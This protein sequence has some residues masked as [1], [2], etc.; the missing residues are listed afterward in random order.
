[1][2]EETWLSEGYEGVGGETPCYRL[3]RVILQLEGGQG[4]FVS[5]VPTSSV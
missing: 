1:M 5:S 4:H 2:E 3:M